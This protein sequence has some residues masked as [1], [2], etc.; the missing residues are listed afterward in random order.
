MK[1]RRNGPNEN[2]PRAQLCYYG[3]SHEY[4]IKQIRAFW[5]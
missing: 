4:M 2:V 5:E 3:L 1:R